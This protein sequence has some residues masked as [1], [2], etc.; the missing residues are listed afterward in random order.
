M[1][2]LASSPEVAHNSPV[3]RANPS[4]RWL[5]AAGVLV[6]M[7]LVAIVTLPVWI[8]P[9][10]ETA[11]TAA[12][13][14]SVTIGKLAVTPARFPRI[15]ASQIAVA[16]S[17]DV[18]DV[19]HLA[20]VDELT[21]TLD[22]SP[23]LHLKMPA[24]PDISIS[25]ANVSAVESKPGVNNYTF[26]TASTQ[27]AS[28]PA[29]L[30]EI[31]AIHIR[32]SHVHVVMSS[33]AADINVAIHTEDRTDANPNG[34]IVG[35]VTGTYARQPITGHLIGGAILN[36]RDATHPYPIDIKLANGPNRLS[37][38]GTVSDPLKFA[39]AD[40]KLD[41]AGQDLAALYPLIGI[42]IPPTPPYR[43]TSA[44]DYAA[45]SIKLTKI[46]GRMGNTDLN[47]EL[48]IDTRPS[49]P[50]LDGALTSRK[51]D[52]QDLAGFIG[53]QPGR[54][55]TPGQ[56]PAQRQ[57]VA[58]AIAS[59][60]LIPDM[61]IDIPKIRSADFHITYRGDSFT[62]GAM[63]F[64][65]LSLRLDIDDGHIRLTNLH[66][67]VGKGQI[68]GFVDMAPVNDNVVTKADLEFQRLDVA[69]LLSALKLVHG[70]GVLGGRATLNATGKSLSEILIRG[71]GTLSLF[72]AGGGNISALII[73]LSGLQLADATLSA[74]GLPNRQQVRCLIGDL[75]LA[76][77]LLQT[78]T[79]ILDTDADRTSGNVSVNLRS[80]QI[81]AHLRTDAKHF[82]I[83]SLPTQIKIGGTL[84]EPS[85]APDPIELG[86][87]GAAAVGLGLLFPPAA[88]LPTIQLGTGEDNACTTLAKGSAVQN[89]APPVPVKPTKRMPR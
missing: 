87:R 4:R 42:P 58:A 73:D 36:L 28:S 10:V 20:T 45:G 83:G 24:I 30:P 84:K 29:A 51:V 43:L 56:T 60:K 25:G 62:G 82:T 11:A 46:A 1:G 31:G 23:L 6:L 2:R 41:V 35:D 34:T 67:G 40:V 22:L 52:L 78:K 85:F 44:V 50:V 37:L 80:E 76:Q 69:R 8:R 14:R 33:V 59:P 3:G 18:P 38:A 61:Q 65:N 72:M 7:L 21:V 53:S 15:T 39:G 48:S 66:V 5:I 88:L 64:D 19:E 12:L 32:D 89:A 16:S 71:N 54:V 27:T 63:P 55:N 81:A 49:R 75:T 74:L 57:A 86:A 17:P 13:G 70:E 77:G 26:K 68:A 47:G 79:L 9:F